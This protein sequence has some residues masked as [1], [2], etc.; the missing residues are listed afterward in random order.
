MRKE[1]RDEPHRHDYSATEA[2]KLGSAL[3]AV[4]ITPA[5]HESGCEIQCRPGTGRTGSVVATVGH[6]VEEVL[7][8]YG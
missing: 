4:Q 3:K 2:L 6:D 8:F 5:G 1:R 7:K